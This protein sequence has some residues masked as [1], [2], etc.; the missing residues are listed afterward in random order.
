MHTTWSSKSKLHFFYSPGRQALSGQRLTAVSERVLSFSEAYIVTQW[1]IVMS[2][3]VEL[4]L[5]S[6]WF[7]MIATER[8]LGLLDTYTVYLY[9]SQWAEFYFLVY[10]WVRVKLLSIMPRISCTTSLIIKLIHNNST[11]TMTN[12]PWVLLPPAC[13]NF[14][15]STLYYDK[16]MRRIPTGREGVDNQFT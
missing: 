5:N 10:L 8:G 14:Q 2:W 11:K 9:D 7:M 3:F 13:K 15:N 1:C 4:I 16:K 6:H 12:L